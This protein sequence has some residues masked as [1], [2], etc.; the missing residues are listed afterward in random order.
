MSEEKHQMPS[1]V[2][3]VSGFVTAAVKH[4]KSG[5]VNVAPEEQ[6]RRLNICNGCEFINAD[7]NRCT[8][9][10]CFLM[11]KTKWA[12]SKCPKGYW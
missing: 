12:T 5:A 2:E 7:K 10:G 4:V 6:E 8:A 1:V 11:T 9:C 3:Q